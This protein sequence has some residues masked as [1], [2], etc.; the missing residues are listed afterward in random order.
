MF[1]ATVNQRFGALIAE[2]GGIPV[3]ADAWSDPGLLVERVDAIVLNGGPDIDPDRYGAK[4]AQSTQEPDPRRDDFE[5]GLVT[6]ALDTGV[7]VLGVCRGMQLVN[8]AMGGT[9]FQALSS[10][11]EL[12][13]YVAS[14]YD[15]PVHCIEIDP[16]SAIEQGLSTR[17]TEVNSVHHQG[18][19]RLGRGLRS[20]ARAP[21]GAVEAVEHEDGLVLGV[22]WHPEFLIGDIGA[23]QVGLF[24][25]FLARCS[26]G[27]EAHP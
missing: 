17:H 26:A 18:I 15:R 20:V 10:V 16:G 3:A 6:E 13:H 19:D 21:D 23:V 22:Q 2:A 8:V 25:A 4:R 14:P 1:N 11:T 24:E 27:T 12:E 5:F 7:P 9:L